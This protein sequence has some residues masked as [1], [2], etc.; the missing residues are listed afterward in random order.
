MVSP[1]QLVYA[2]VVQHCLYLR[3]NPRKHNVDSLCER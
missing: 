3:L 1:N 2:C